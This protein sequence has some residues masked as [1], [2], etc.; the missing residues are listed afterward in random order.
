L[1]PLASMVAQTALA[2]FIG[3]G[4]FAV[5]LR[6]MRHLYAARQAVLIEAAERL[7]AGR[8]TLVPDDAGMHVLG[9]PAEG[10]SFDDEA[11]AAAAAKQGIVVP[12]LS[13]HYEGP[14]KR[15]GL[16]FGY[17]GVAPERIGPA[18]ARLAAVIDAAGDRS[19]MIAARSPRATTAA[20]ADAAAPRARARR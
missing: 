20:A 16:M 3:E 11:V 2:A 12:P 18:L 19:A 9:F 1:E 8:L 13:R 14:E 17:A 6:R 4:H 7:L 5:H 15:S 10:K